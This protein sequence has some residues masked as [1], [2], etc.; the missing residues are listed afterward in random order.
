MRNSN[1]SKFLIVATFLLI[2]IVAIAQ[3]KPDAPAENYVKTHY[4]KY[5]YR[6]PMRDGKKLFT[7]VYVPKDTAQAYPIMMD[8]TPYSVAPYGE[9]Q[10]Q[11]TLGP[12]DEF[13][14]SGYIFAYQD[15]RGRYMSEGTFVEMRPHIDV[16]KA[17]QDVDD[18]S[19]TYDTIDY[20][21][22]HV[23]NNNG[24]VGIWGI[25]YPGFYTSASMIDSHPALVAASPQAPMTDLFLGDDGYHGGAFMLSANFGF[26]GRYFR[27]QTEP[28]APKP[29]VPADFGTIDS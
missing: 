21:L 12:S 25:S 15:V 5:E 24:K 14:K 19:D 26:Y 3:Q 27:P 7:S 20:L 18:A 2:S 17:P 23:P 8:R 16:K 13:E 4:T 29:T 28:Q 22:K 6:I 9:D 10:Y 11:T 1:R